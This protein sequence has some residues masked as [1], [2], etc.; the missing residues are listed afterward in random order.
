MNGTGLL[1]IKVG[2]L[3]GKPVSAAVEAKQLFDA[4]TDAGVAP[5]KV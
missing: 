1:P 5:G 3:S 2:G 4:A